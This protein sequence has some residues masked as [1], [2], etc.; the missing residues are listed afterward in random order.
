MQDELKACPFC[1]G[2]NIATVQT[3]ERCYMTCDDCVAEGPLANN[4]A[5]AI[6]AWTT[7]ADPALAD[8]EAEARNADGESYRDMWLASTSN[9]ARVA[10]KA[11]TYRAMLE[12]LEPIL[13]Q[14]GTWMLTHDLDMRPDSPDDCLETEADAIRAA[15]EPQP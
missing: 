6:T 15:M 12:R 4:E 14:Y 13:R 3:D 9:V 7:R 5:E 10:A 11:N 8:A 1:G 2:S